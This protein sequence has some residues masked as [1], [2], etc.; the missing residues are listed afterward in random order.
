MSTNHPITNWLPITKKEIELSKIKG[1]KEVKAISNNRY[2]LVADLKNDIRSDVFRFAVD[3]NLILIGMNQ[4][5]FSVED[6]FQQ[7]TK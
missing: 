6:V 7:L 1:V 3:R 5:V 4:E 2:Q